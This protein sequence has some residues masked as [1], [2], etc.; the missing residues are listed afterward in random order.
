MSF[1]WPWVL[2]ALPLPWLLQRLKKQPTGEDSA[3][4][5]PPRLRD[6]LQSVHHQKIA[7]R[8][9]SENALRWIAWV[10]LLLALAQ[11]ISKGD[12]TVQPA[13]GRAITLAI[14]LSG[15]MER[16]DFELDTNVA[17]RLDVVK[18]VAG[19][20]V[21]ARRGDRIGLVL[22]GKQAFIA[23]LPTFDVDAV[24]HQLAAAGIGMAGRAT[25]IGD[26]LGL[27]IQTLR[28]D[29]ASERAIILLSDGTNNAGSAEPESA[30]ALASSMN[31]RVHTIALGST[32]AERSG[33]AIEASA[34]LDEATLRAIAESSKGSFFRATST[35]ELQDIY[36][37]IDELE[38]ADTESPPIIVS[39]DWRHLPLLLLLG[40]LLVAS[41]LSFINR[42]HKGGVKTFA[43]QTTSPANTLNSEQ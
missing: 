1:V 27:A 7:S 37:A 34:D 20:F 17:N 40:T 9:S 21:E 24:R 33:Y 43:N 38:A 5:L 29:P 31:I 6:A 4:E 12:V 32:G 36:K 28:N 2:I 30:A 26:A 11:P 14:D 22:F 41:L 16:K 25:A 39:R 15:S 8:W 19:Q 3:I 10:S 18:N 13:T 23:N 42:W 35:E